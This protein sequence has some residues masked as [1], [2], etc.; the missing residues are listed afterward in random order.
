MARVFLSR[1]TGPP[2][3]PALFASVPLSSILYPERKV[4]FLPSPQAAFLG[5]KCLPC[6]HT[7]SASY[8]STYPP[9]AANMPWAHETFPNTPARMNHFLLHSVTALVTTG[10]HISYSSYLSNPGTTD[11]FRVTFCS[12]QHLVW[13]YTE[14]RKLNIWLQLSININGSNF[15]L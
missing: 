4:S 5:L 2:H 11:P 8:N 7:I 12:P 3:L 6:F 1:H 10:L 14:N 13:L 9:D 15:E